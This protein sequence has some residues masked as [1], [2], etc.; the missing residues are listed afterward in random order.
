MAM[1]RR[2]PGEPLPVVI[3]GGL[4]QSVY[5]HC[6]AGMRPFW[7]TLG[8]CIA[9]IGKLRAIK[10][11]EAVSRSPDMSAWAHEVADG[12]GRVELLCPLR[13]LSAS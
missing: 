9:R 13:I 6:A 7:L 2:V 12:P 1:Y 3:V 8:A 11:E 4:G 10:P 5:V